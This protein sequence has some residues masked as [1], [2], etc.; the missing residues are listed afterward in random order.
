MIAWRNSF[1]VEQTQIQILIPPI[2]YLCDLSLRLS[3]LSCQMW[4]AML[5]LL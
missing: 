4:V 1:G 2:T 3:F 5:S